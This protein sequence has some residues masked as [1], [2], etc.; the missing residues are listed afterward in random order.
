[1]PISLD[2]TPI[3]TAAV[4]GITGVL[5]GWIGYL[6]ARHQGSVELEKL[7]LEKS[8]LQR[9]LEEPHFQHRQAVYHDY[10]DS[11]F[12]WHQ[13]KSGVDP[14]EGPDEY[15]AWAREFEHRLSA[16]SLFGT[17]VVYEKALELSKVIEQYMGETS[18]T[19]EGYAGE[20]VFLAKWRELVEAMRLDT[21]PEVPAAASDS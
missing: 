13:E 20:A 1:M 21:A 12:R 5:A 2:A 14:I 18:R 6:A 8:R 4:T 16:V 15:N 7:K 11:A 3:L 19:D 17:Q 9:E 10:L